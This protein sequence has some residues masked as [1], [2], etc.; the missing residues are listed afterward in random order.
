MS[1]PPEVVKVIDE[2]RLIDPESYERRYRTACGEALLPGY[3]IVTWAADA[4]H[5]TYDELARYLGPYDSV[6]AARLAHDRIGAT[7][8]SRDC[9]QSSPL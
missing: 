7:A 9:S 5:T 3:Y 8:S 2:H 4:S 6:E 1:Y